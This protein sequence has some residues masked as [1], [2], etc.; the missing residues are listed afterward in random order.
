M[1]ERANMRC[2]ILIQI[3]FSGSI[4]TLSGREK[5]CFIAYRRVIPVFGAFAKIV[6]A[7]QN[8]GRLEF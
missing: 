4:P 6:N 3:V 1:L 8:V 2:K 7:E 5:S